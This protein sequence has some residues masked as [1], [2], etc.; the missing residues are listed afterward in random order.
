MEN[1]TGGVPKPSPSEWMRGKVSL[2]SSVRFLINVCTW[3]LSFV[4]G[5]FRGSTWKSVG[6]LFSHR[7][8]TVW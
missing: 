6:L 3:I 8:V 5:G 1:K 2:G 4:C 7:L